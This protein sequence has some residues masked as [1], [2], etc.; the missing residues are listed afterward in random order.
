VAGV[1][2]RRKFAGDEVKARA[3]YQYKENGTRCS[4]PSLEERRERQD[5]RRVRVAT[6]SGWAPKEAAE[7]QE[8]EQ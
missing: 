6:L 3:E 4:R 8:A 1:V 7:S 5:S 2:S